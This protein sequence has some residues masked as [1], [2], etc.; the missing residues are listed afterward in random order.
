M[1]DSNYS[2]DTSDLLHRL[3]SGFLVAAWGYVAFSS[4]GMEMALRLSFFLLPVACIWFPEELGSVTGVFHHSFDRVD[5]P[6][7]PGFLRW[8]CWI[9]VMVIPPILIF[10]VWQ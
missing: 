6:S 7:H 1:F 10:K 8:T 4:G 3:F 9:I 5:A 2:I